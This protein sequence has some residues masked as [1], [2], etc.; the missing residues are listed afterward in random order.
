MEALKEVESQTPGILLHLCLLCDRLLNTAEPVS[1]AEPEGGI[2]WDVATANELEASWLKKWL[3]LMKTTLAEIFGIQLDLQ[4][5]MLTA[6]SG[7]IAGLAKQLTCFFAT[8][9]LLDFAS[10]V[11]QVARGICG[12]ISQI[13]PA[14]GEK[15]QRGDLKNLQ[16]V[17]LVPFGIPEIEV[18]FAAQ[19]CFR[20]V[21]HVDGME[22]TIIY[23]DLNT[24]GPE[25]IEIL[26]QEVDD[27]GRP[28]LYHLVRC[29]LVPSHEV[30]H[31]VQSQL[32]QRDTSDQSW[33]AEFDASWISSQSSSVFL[34]CRTI[35]R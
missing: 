23:P 20:K 34:D 25:H 35:G 27:K 29:L 7:D 4:G 1:K 11:E 8:P 28:F 10:V 31:L 13:C 5:S 32:G 26:E 22:H 9:G 6:T 3:P 30:V 19:S 17:P 21:S 24:L 16:V 15:D 12:T 33:S 2:G 18:S 14:I